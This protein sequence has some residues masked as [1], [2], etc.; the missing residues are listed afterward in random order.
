MEEEGIKWLHSPTGLS[1][2]MACTEGTG[3]TIFSCLTVR[4]LSVWKIYT[5]DIAQETHPSTSLAPPC[6]SSFFSQQHE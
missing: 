2:P 3:D 6:R 5:T 4:K 1:L